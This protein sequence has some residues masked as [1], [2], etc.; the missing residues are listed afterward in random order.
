MAQ[1][2]PK[3]MQIMYNIL[4][5]FL[6]VGT[7]I[8]IFI[9]DMGYYSKLEVPIG[10]TS[11]TSNP[12]PNP[13]VDW[14]WA[15]CWQWLTVVCC[16]CCLLPINST[17]GVA[18]LSIAPCVDCLLSSLLQKPPTVDIVDHA[19]ATLVWFGVFGSLFWFDLGFWFLIHYKYQWLKL[20]VNP[21][22]K[23]KKEG[24]IQHASLR[25]CMQACKAKRDID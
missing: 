9:F 23:V 12:K 24:T 19:L 3:K 17:R 7:E 6:E 4:K 25:I 1:T 14:P 21:K 2:K 10:A 20:A 13:F 15:C 22:F 8:S 16:F 5:I 18:F 11:Y